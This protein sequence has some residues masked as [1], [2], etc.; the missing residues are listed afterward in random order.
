MINN[1]GIN[2]ALKNTTP[3]EEVIIEEKIL[4]IT[5]KYNCYYIILEN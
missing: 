2:L 4:V 5:K 3:S 1:Y